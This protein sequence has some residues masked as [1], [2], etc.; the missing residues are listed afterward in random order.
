MIKNNTTELSDFKAGSTDINKIYNGSTL[1]WERGPSVTYHFIT[2]IGTN[3]A[4]RTTMLPDME[5]IV[6]ITPAGTAQWPKMAISNSGRLVLNMTIGTFYSDDFGDSWTQINSEWWRDL[7]YNPVEDFF[8][9]QRGNNSQTSYSTDGINFFDGGGAYYFAN[10]PGW[11]KYHN[12]YTLPVNQQSYQRAFVNGVTTGSPTHTRRPS[13][14]VITEYSIANSELYL[15]GF[16]DHPDTDN[17]T[18]LPVSVSSDPNAL[19]NPQIASFDDTKYIDVRSISAPNDKVYTNL[20]RYVEEYDTFVFGFYVEN[21]GG[22]FSEYRIYAAPSSYLDSGLQAELVVQ[23]NI[24]SNV[25]ADNGPYE[26]ITFE[27]G[28]ITKI[29]IYNKTGTY[30]KFNGGDILDNANWDPTHNAVYIPGFINR[31]VSYPNS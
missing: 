24:Y 6:D 27:E 8:F 15:T 5:D 17:G 29:A 21:I 7:V 31:I 12:G 23:T 28:G 16:Y 25:M 4:Y 13:N 9:A 18:R 14:Y 3:R 30:V 2:A 11:L 20:F 1:L 26:L 19:I 22:G 10:F